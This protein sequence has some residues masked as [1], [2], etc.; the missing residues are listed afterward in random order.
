MYMCIYIYI[1]SNLYLYLYL[2]TDVYLHIYKH[3]CIIT[4]FDVYVYTQAHT[5]TNR[6][7]HTHIHTHT[8]TKT[9][10]YTQKIPTHTHTHT[11]LDLY[12]GLRGTLALKDLGEHTSV[13]I[14]GRGD[15]A[16]SRNCFQTRT[17]VFK[18]FQ[19]LINYQSH[20]IY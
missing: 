12:A 20:A 3:N 9:H 11:G 13:C 10:T 6:H 16:C 1:Y 19:M 4:G 5:K 17:S 18:V 2:C 8:Q 15:S 7:T 14:R